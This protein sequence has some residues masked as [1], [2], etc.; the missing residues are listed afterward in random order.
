VFGDVV[1]VTLC[2]DAALSGSAST[3]VDCTQ[4]RPAILRSGAIAESAVQAV[5]A[6]T[7]STQTDPG[8]GRPDG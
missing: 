5:L 4:T 3:V 1:A 7:G 8:P 6:E 2:A